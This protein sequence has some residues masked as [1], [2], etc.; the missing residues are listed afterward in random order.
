[1]EKYQQQKMQKYTPENLKRITGRDKKNTAFPRKSP[2]SGTK[3][4]IKFHL[5]TMDSAILFIYS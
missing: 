5:P 1:M 3:F 4:Q 2:I